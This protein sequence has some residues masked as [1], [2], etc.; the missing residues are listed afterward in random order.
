MPGP[1]GHVHAGT[2]VAQGSTERFLQVYPQ[3]PPGVSGYN[4]NYLGPIAGV[5]L[6]TDRIVQSSQSKATKKST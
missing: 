2:P 6:I 1:P 3:E 5:K 4:G